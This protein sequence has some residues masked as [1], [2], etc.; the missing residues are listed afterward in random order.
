MKINKVFLDL[1]NT[2]LDF[3]GAVYS[4]FGLRREQVEEP[5]EWHGIHKSLSEALGRVV[6]EAELWARVADAG[7]DWWANLEWLP[8]SDDMVGQIKRLGL[9]IFVCSSTG[10]IPSSATGK[11]RWVARNIPSCE[12][13]LCRNKHFLAAP[14][15]LLIDDAPHQVESFRKAGGKAICYPQPWNVA[16]AEFE[17]WVGYQPIP[18]TPRR[19]TWVTE[20]LAELQR[21]LRI[22]HGL[23]DHPLR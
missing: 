3:N 11:L 18:T 6:T 12:T 13:F 8:G 10:W 5:T 16:Q 1:D 20:Q 22:C 17:K 21:N 9:E 4:L 23:V 19:G 2:L 14:D 7:E 15:R